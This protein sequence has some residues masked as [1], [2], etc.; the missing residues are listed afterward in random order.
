MQKRKIQLIAAIAVATATFSASTAVQAAGPLGSAATPS[1]WYRAD[2][3]AGLDANGNPNPLPSDQSFVGTWVNLSDP[4]RNAVQNLSVNRRPTFRTGVAGENGT[5]PVVRFNLNS[6]VPTQ[7]GLAYS[8]DEFLYFLDRVANTAESDL[9]VFLVANESRTSGTNRNTVLNT[10]PNASTS[11]GLVLSYSASNQVSYAHI[12]H[13]IGSDVTAAPLQTVTLAEDDF[14]LSMVSRDGLQT[15]LSHFSDLSTGTRTDTWGGTRVVN[16]TTYV[17]FTPSTLTLPNGVPVTQIGTEGGSNYFFGDIAEILI[18]DN[19]TL[20]T[21]DRTIVTNYLGEKYGIAS[22]DLADFP[23]D[24]NADYQVNFDDLLALAR[25]YNSQNTGGRN[26]GDF[27]RNG[28]TDFD[29]LLVLARNYNT[30]LSTEALS[31]LR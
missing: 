26:T 28:V 15:T 11:N 10:R 25:S 27:D 16:G 7:D 5:L 18:Y 19:A 1:N 6:D 29:D 12:N 4:A 21:R 3:L 22:A 2:A 9:T 23:G 13:N 31:T 30:S 24:T 14:N 20:G 8:A 17:G